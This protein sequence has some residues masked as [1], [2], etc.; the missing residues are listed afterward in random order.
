M[1]LEFDHFRKAHLQFGHFGKAHDPL[2]LSDSQTIPPPVVLASE[3]ILTH[4]SGH[5]PIGTWLMA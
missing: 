1:L 5:L 2:V 3:G 4:K